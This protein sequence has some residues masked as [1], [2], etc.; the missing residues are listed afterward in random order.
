MRERIGD[1]VANASDDDYIEEEDSYVSSITVSDHGTIFYGTSDPDATG[2][3]LGAISAV[4]DP[5]LGTDTLA[6]MEV[7]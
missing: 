3:T 1:G 2:N 4:T 7:F 5:F 6:W